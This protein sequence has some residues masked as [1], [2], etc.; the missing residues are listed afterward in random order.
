LS[1]ILGQFFKD[2]HKALDH[3]ILC[4][5]TVPDIPLANSKESSTIVVIKVLLG[6]SIA[7]QTTFDEC[8]FCGK[9]LSDKHSFGLSNSRCKVQKIGCTP[10][11]KKAAECTGF[12]DEQDPNSKEKGKMDKGQVEVL[13]KK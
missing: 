13:T 8:C 12:Y 9:I 2:P 3:D 7:L 10:G 5:I 11:I 1:L 6:F 4:R